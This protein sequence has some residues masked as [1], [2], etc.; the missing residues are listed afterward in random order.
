M[1][2]QKKIRDFF[3]KN[4]EARDGINISSGK[5]PLVAKNLRH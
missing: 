2:E 4:E 3:S 1:K 5:L